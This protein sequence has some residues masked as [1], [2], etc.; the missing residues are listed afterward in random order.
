MAR[1]ARSHDDGLLDDALDALL[2]LSRRVP[3]V[4]V[5]VSVSFAAGGVYL[6]RLD[7]HSVWGFGVLLGYLCFAMAI[8]FGVVGAVGL[9]QGARQRHIRA[10]RLEHTTTPEA[11]MAMNWRQF[12]QLVADLY[13]RQGYRVREVG[14][15]GDAGVD[16]VL[17]GSGD[18]E[19]L[20]QCKQYRVWRVG[21]PKVREFY[22]AMAAHQTRCE[23]I[24]VTCGTFTAPAKQFAEGKPIRLIDG[25]GLLLM[26]RHTNT[27]APAVSQHLTSGATG[28]L[29]PRAP[30]APSS[31]AGATPPCPSCGSAMVSRTAGRGPRKGEAFWGCPRFPACRGTR[32]LAG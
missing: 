18:V 14:G 31:T 9:V 19:H 13:R 2:A 29:T 17:V 8:L 4:G 6:A 15:S 28:D 12:E 20:V 1:R 25:D 26:L 3:V 11:L 10:D 22:G 30:A 7:P 32:T 23:G 27:V 24:F 16:L 21:E 5:V